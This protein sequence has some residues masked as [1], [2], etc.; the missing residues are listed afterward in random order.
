MSDLDAKTKAD[1]AE[2]ASTAGFGIWRRPR[3]PMFHLCTLD[4]HQIDRPLDKGVW[5]IIG[6]EDMD[7]EQ[8]I[9]LLRRFSPAEPNGRTDEEYCAW[10]GLYEAGHM[11]IW[12]RGPDLLDPRFLMP[13]V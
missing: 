13:N 6:F 2:S 4:V 3:P 10:R 8:E 11:H 9:F 7:S 12:R 5:E 1:G